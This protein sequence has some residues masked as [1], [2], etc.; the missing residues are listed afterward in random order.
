MLFPHPSAP[1]PPPFP[2]GGDEE[3]AAPPPT[4]AAEIEVT[5]AGT[6]QLVSPIVSKSTSL[7]SGTI[8]VAVAV[9]VAVVV[10]GTAAVV[11]VA[12]RTGRE[13]KLPPFAGVPSAPTLR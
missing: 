8:G 10:C 6:V 12:T 11:V 7:V 5:L 3:P 4:Q 9:V 1:P 13:P 2:P